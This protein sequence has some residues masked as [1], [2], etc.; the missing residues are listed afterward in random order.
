MV[1]S[2]EWV[3]V[4]VAGVEDAHLLYTIS[5]IEKKL[6]IQSIYSPIDETKM[7]AD[8]KRRL[9]GKENE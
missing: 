1:K 3:D 9:K 5:A 8:T 2:D 7:E 6:L 4:V